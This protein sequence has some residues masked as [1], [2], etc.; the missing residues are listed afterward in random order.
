M[1]QVVECLPSM[2]RALYLAPGTTRKKNHLTLEYRVP[3][4][5]LGL[6]KCVRECLSLS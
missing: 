3:L 4:V 6:P 2:H 5:I 1:V